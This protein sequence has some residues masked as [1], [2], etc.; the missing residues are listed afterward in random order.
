MTMKIGKVNHMENFKNEKEKYLNLLSQEDATDAQVKDAADKMF[1]ALQEDL[2][3]KIVAEARMGM[4]DSVVLA[5]RGVNVLTTEEREF[6][7]A[8]VI[9]G[10]F[11]DAKILPSTTQQRVFE[12][13]VKE[14]PLLE[15][16]GL[17]DLGAVTKFVYSDPTRTYMW[18]EL[19]T[20]I[21]GQVNA[22]FREEQI[23][24]LKLTA[25]AVIP[26]D[27]IDLGPEYIE[28]YVR[29]LLIE[30]I[31]TGLEFGYVNGRGPT[32]SEPVGL[33]KDVDPVSGAVTDKV[34]SGTLT[35]APSQYGET[36]TGELYNV[37]KL[38]STNAKN[39][40][41]NVSNLVVMIINPID[42]IGVQFRNTI[43]TSDGR[44]VTALPYNITV[45]ESEQVPVGKAIFMLRGEYIAAIAGAY[46]LKR[47]DQTLAIEDAVLYTIKRYANGRPK[48]NKSAVVFDLDIQFP[49]TP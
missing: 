48:D 24:Q 8:A 15:A 14:H 45:V 35:F 34:S 38:L 33:L 4:N 19:F 28:L 31:A 16:L 44:F 13:L 40:A 3:A 5:G 17:Q 7:N 1:N 41:R 23:T 12:G 46:Q 36:V 18:K 47:F 30:S 9:D 20:D 26:N 42:A 10:G 39:E 21:Q 43:Q 2:S 37:V 6:F 25:L 29:T 22:A 32:M 11:N 49:V 27:M